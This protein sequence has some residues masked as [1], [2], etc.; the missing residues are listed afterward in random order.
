KATDVNLSQ[1]VTVAFDAAGNMLIGERGANRVRSVKPDGTISTIAG[2]G[3]NSFFGDGGPATAAAFQ[4]VGGIHIAPDGTIYIRDANDG[5]VRKFDTKGIITTFARRGS[6]PNATGGP[7]T[8]ASLGTPTAV[9]VD[10]LGNLYF[11]ENA[12]NRARRVS[13]QG[14]L[15][16]IA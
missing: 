6:D 1:P 9:T 16:N 14:I 15:T 11:A 10:A 7:A 12:G 3:T 13:P 4:S 2:N 8:D 5:A